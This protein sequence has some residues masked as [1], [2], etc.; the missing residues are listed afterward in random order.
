MAKMGDTE[1]AEKDQTKEVFMRKAIVV[2][3]LWVDGVMESPEEWA[4]S[5][6]ND[7]M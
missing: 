1:T 6:S 5:C 7:E 4:F 3:S 2:E